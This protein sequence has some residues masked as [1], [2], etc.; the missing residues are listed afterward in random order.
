[1]DVH[2]ADLIGA[3]PVIV[4]VSP[5]GMI[6]TVALVES[7]RCHNRR[8]TDLSRDTALRTI[9][10]KVAAAVDT[11]YSDVI[12][13]ILDGARAGIWRCTNGLDHDTQ[14]IGLHA[15]HCLHSMVRLVLSFSMNCTGRSK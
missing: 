3:A 2:R 8:A 10:F 14:E 5:D 12:Q 4:P 9:A 11:A 6:D 15:V 7:A 1:L 13:Q